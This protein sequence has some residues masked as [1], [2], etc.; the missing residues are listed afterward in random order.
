VF[1]LVLIGVPVLEL[2]VFIEVGLALGW[3]P[4]LVLLIGTSLL[5]MWIARA[6][7]RATIERVSL[8]VA[9]GRPP[10]RAAI[11]GALGLLGAM[12]L[13]VPGFVTDVLGALLLLPA[14]R[15]LARRWMSRHYAAR[16]MSFVATAAR[17][18]P[19]RRGTPPADVES[20]AID[21]DRERL[22]P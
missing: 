2:F 14:G 16:M 7:G 18:T 9:E 12:L 5:G 4:A 10:A 13:V 11:D 21:D 19:P 6:Q 1:L 8:A 15:A 3:L 20:T 22:E 17:F